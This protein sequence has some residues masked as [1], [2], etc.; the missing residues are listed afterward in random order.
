M[1]IKTKSAGVLFTF[2]S[3]FQSF[4][5]PGPPRASSPWLRCGCPRRPLWSRGENSG[6][7]RNLPPGKVYGHRGP[8]QS[9]VNPALFEK[10]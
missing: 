4:R 3:D 9:V 8:A 2:A 6:K 1:A 10:L 5:F 7:I